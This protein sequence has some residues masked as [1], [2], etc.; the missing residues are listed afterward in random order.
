MLILAVC[1][2]MLAAAIAAGQLAVPGLLFLVSLWTVCN[3]FMAK[4]KVKRARAFHLSQG[5]LGRGV[6]TH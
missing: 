5:T 3:G 4:A 2:L 1:L 6:E